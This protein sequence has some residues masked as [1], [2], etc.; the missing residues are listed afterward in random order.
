MVRAARPVRPGNGQSRKEAASVT[1][2]EGLARDACSI[3]RAQ[4]FIDPD[5]FQWATVPPA[6]ICHAERLDGEGKAKTADAIR[7]VDERNQLPLRAGPSQ[8]VAAISGRRWASRRGG[9]MIT[10]QTRGR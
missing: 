6:T 3:L 2:I 4:A 10:F 5:A 1:T 9:G 8:I 7:G